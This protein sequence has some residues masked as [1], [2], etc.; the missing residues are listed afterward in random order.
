MNSTGLQKR[1]SEGIENSKNSKTA[2]NL[3]DF[4]EQYNLSLT[5]NCK[6]FPP[7]AEWAVPSP[8]VTFSSESNQSVLFHDFTTA[9]LVLTTT[10]N[11]RHLLKIFDVIEYSLHKETM[12]VNK[13]GK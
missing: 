10:R 4:L 11:K 6:C 13:V 9:T 1:F 3:F 2:E 7:L 8:S 12:W 5:Q